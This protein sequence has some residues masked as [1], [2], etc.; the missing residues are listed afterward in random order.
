MPE[1]VTFDPTTGKYLFTNFVTVVAA[2]PTVFV[3]PLVFDNTA[4]TGGL[5][6]WN[7]TAYVQVGLATS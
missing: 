1:E 6:C 5:Y 7:G 2:P 4:D 3:T